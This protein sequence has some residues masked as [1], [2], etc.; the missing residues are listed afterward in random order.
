M[1]DRRLC[2]IAANPMP[3]NLLPLVAVAGVLGAVA[4]ATRPQPSAATLLPPTPRSAAVAPDAAADRP[5]QILAS[6]ELATMRIDWISAD[7]PLLLAVYDRQGRAI[8]LYEHLE[9]AMASHPEIHAAFFL[10]AFEG[11]PLGEADL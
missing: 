2:K 7:C 5:A 10:G 11:L 4:V 1:S 9:H 8:G 6:V 3:R